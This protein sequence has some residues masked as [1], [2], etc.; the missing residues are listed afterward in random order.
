MIE[1]RNFRPR[2]DQVIR[3]CIPDPGIQSVLHFCHS[4]TRGGHYGLS[5]TTWK[6]LDYGLYWPTIL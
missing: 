4:V 5:R 3:K 1:S 2:N 6:V